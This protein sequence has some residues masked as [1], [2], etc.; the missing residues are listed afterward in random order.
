MGTTNVSP[1]YPVLIIDDHELFSTSLRVALHGRGIEA[2]QLPV[3]GLAEFRQRLKGGVRDDPVGLVV[4]DLDL[5]RDAEGRRISGVDLIKD[6]RAHGWA[7]LIVSASADSPAV[8]AG[9]AAGALGSVPK[10][11]SFEALLQAV[12]TAAV[13]EP[14]MTE[15]ERQTW[16]KRHHGYQAQQREL[17]RR[18][19]RLSRREREVL[20]MLAEGHRAG[21]IAERFVVSMTTVRTQI[22]A[23]LTKLEVN[24]QLEAVAMLRQRPQW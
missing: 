2:Y 22:R 12:L 18:L 17:S 15:G 20:E 1:G 10:S 21:D 24:S 16:L 23:V 8:A 7:V 13:G 11:Q 5:G 6:L 14:I 19:S 9:I 3:D 4:L